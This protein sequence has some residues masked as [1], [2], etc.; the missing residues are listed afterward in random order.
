MDKELLHEKLSALL[1]NELAEEERSE[2]EA[3]IRSDPEVGREWEELK[4]V[5][6]LFRGMPRYEAPKELTAGL[7]PEKRI[8]P[9]SFGR[10]HSTRRAAWP[11]LAAAAALVVIFGLVVMRLPESGLFN[12]A[13]VEQAPASE[14]VVS[15][16]EKSGQAVASEEVPEHAADV[17]VGRAAPAPRRRGREGRDVSQKDLA[18]QPHLPLE[19]EVAVGEEVEGPGYA[20]DAVVGRA[21]PQPETNTSGVEEKA[22]AESPAFSAK[23]APP[24]PMVETLPQG[25]RRPKMESAAPGEIESDEGVWAD[26]DRTL[27]R[28]GE[29]VFEKRENAWVQS[30]YDNEQTVTLVRD[31]KKAKALCAREPAVSDILAMDNEVVFEFDG[32]WYRAPSVESTAESH[33]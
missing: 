21:S 19:D 27:K 16:T 33:P 30:T 8:R 29:R 3:L 13:R 4:R 28:I 10:P 7:R 5:D 24:Q 25:S 11:L 31:S 9:L 32:V 17:T 22:D 18:E 6:S 20:G 26:E 12:T 2:L 15:D 23:E 14:S 1:D